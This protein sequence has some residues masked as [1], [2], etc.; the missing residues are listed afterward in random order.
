MSQYVINGKAIT[1]ACPNH[2]AGSIQ[3][4]VSSN[5]EGIQASGKCLVCG[6]KAVVTITEEK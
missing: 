1:M 3:G 2:G 4:N 5:D 6:A